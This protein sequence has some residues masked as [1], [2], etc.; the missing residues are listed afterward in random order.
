MLSVVSSA[1]CWWHRMMRT[2]S[3]RL[4]LVE[5]VRSAK[6]ALMTWFHSVLHCFELF[7]GP[8]LPKTLCLRE[9][10]TLGL[11]LLWIMI[12]SH[13]PAITRVLWA[14]NSDTY[15]PWNRYVSGYVCQ[16]VLGSGRLLHGRAQRPERSAFEFYDPDCSQDKCEFAPDFCIFNRNSRKCSST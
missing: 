8:V 7:L 16:L 4:R 6:A 13:N 10:M 3:P 5:C 11:T 1:C 9:V 12:M 2:G 15:I 14:R